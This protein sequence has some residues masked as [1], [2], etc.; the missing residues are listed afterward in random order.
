VQVLAVTAVDAVPG[1]S[2]EITCHAWLW[3]GRSVGEGPP[4]WLACPEVG[5]L[6]GGGGYCFVQVAAF[7]CCEAAAFVGGCPEPLDC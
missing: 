6:A 2:P 4:G 3:G 5:G 7:F 1:C